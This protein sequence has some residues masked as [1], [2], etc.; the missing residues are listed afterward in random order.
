MKFDLDSLT[1]GDYDNQSIIQNFCN[2]FILYGMG[3]RFQIGNEMLYNTFKLD[4]TI[5]PF[6]ME[7]AW[8]GNE[9]ESLDSNFSG[10][11]ED[12]VWRK[13]SIF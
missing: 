12:A 7:S 5:L 13:I 6:R 2:F 11:L 4:L 3:S 1:S 10:C 8:D 9:V